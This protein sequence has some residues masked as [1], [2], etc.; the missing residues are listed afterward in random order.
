MYEREVILWVRI[1]KHCEM[2]ALMWVMRLFGGPNRGGHDPKKYMQAFDLLMKE[3]YGEG[4]YIY[5]S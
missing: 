3:L 4:A 5:I 1:Q 2:V